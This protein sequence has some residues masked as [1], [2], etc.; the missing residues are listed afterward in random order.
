ML[1]FLLL[2]LNTINFTKCNNSTF[3]KSH[4]EEVEEYQKH[5]DNTD[6]DHINEFLTFQDFIALFQDAKY[7]TIKNYLQE[8]FH[9]FQELKKNMQ[10]SD[11]IDILF[12]KNSDD[13]RINPASYSSL[14]RRVL[15]NSTFHDSP[16]SEQLIILIHEL[17]HALQHMHL[18]IIEFCR[19]DEVQIEREADMNVLH[20]IQCL[21][22]LK[23]FEITAS[24]DPSILAKGYLSPQSISVYRKTRSKGNFCKAHSQHT[25]EN[26]RLRNLV[27][28][29]K[30]NTIEKEELINLDEQVGT[31]SNR[32]SSLRFSK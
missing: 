31:L 30:L 19:A 8:L 3:E 10:I 25:P 23:I 14:Y 15:I 9:T 7:L 27:F 18:G 4:E 22:C 12:A 2:C 11:D 21:A 28:Q 16:P 24:S 6:N 5:A 32:L 26:Q 20:T 29:K 1:F 13:S 17:T